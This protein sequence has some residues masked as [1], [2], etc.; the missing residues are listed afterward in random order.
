MLR[1]VFDWVPSALDA[2]LDEAGNMR[3]VVGGRGVEFSKEMYVHGAPGGYTR[4]IGIYNDD[5]FCDE[6]D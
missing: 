2:L 1:V 4:S 6:A 3:C 5:A